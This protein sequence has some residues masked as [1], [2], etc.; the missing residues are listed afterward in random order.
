MDCRKSISAGVP[1]G[2]QI[3]LM[4]DIA[5]ESL[6]QAVLIQEREM[7]KSCS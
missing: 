6:P 7:E 4:R 3:T 2:Q 1:P 5:G